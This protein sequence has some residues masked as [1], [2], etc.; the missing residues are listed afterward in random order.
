MSVRFL[1]IGG[2]EKIAAIAGLNVICDGTSE[3][4]LADAHHRVGAD[5]DGENIRQFRQSRGYTGFPV[6][7]VSPRNAICAP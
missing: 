4:R 3:R 7:V 2:D 6:F 5:V 1:L